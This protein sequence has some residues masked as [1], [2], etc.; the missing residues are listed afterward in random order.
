MAHSG[1]ISPNSILRELVGS[2][3]N[4][5]EHVRKVISTMSPCDKDYGNAHVRIGVTGRGKTPYHKVFYLAADGREEPYGT[6]YGERRD[7]SFEAGRGAWSAR[8][9]SYEDILTLIGE[10]RGFSKKVITHD[11]T[12]WG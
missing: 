9:S 6:V 5:E 11:Q 4:P 1:A 7:D 8:S 2:L 3:S 10:I 12:Q